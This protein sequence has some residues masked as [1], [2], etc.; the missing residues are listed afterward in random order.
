MCT[1]PAHSPSLSSTSQTFRG[2]A[3]CR[4]CTSSRSD[5]LLRCCTTTIGMENSSGSP[6][7][8]FIIADRPPHEVPIATIEY[9]T[10]SNLPED[11][12][13]GRHLLIT[14]LVCHEPQRLLA[15]QHQH[16]EHREAVV[17]KA[18][19]LRLQRLVEVDEHVA[20]EDDVELAE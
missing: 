19:Y 13:R 18:V 14:L 7:S 5:S 4:S 17:E 6:P 9:G 3:S 20:A 2:V 10:L 12:F 15:A 8:S 11:F 16:S 1:V